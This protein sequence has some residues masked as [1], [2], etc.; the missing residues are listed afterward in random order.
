MEAQANRVTPEGA[1]ESQ[2]A[3]KMIKRHHIACTVP[4]PGLRLTR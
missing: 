1:A 2:V 3:T 4:K